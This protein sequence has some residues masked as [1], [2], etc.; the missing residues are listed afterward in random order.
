MSSKTPPLLTIRLLNINRPQ[1]NRVAQVLTGNCNLQRH[2]KTT[3][4]GESSLCPKCSQEDETPNH[5]V[6]TCKLYQDILVKCFFNV[7]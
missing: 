7:K 1:L 2:K 4:H 6:G 5:H 3:G